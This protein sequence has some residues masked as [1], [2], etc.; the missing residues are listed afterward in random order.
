MK[1]L[2]FDSGIREYQING[3]GVLRFNPCDP[4]LY[5]R[6]IDAAEKVQQVEDRLVSSARQLNAESADNH[7]ET[8]L[9]LLAEA[10][11]EAKQILTDVFG[12]ENDFNKIMGGVNLLA[13]AGNGERVITNLLYALLPVFQEGIE[14]YA[15][16][17]AGAAVAIANQRRGKK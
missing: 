7:G 16:Q 14:S 1:Q 6:F 4:N 13:V 11:K 3:N 17:T 9:R 15:R 10:D 5:V 2:N 12:Q 8:V